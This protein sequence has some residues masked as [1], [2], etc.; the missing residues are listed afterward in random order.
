MTILTIIL[1]IIPGILFSFF[2]IRQDKYEQEPK[3]T[4]AISFALGM[5]VTGIAYGIEKW[6]DDK[7]QLYT[8]A[9]NIDTYEHFGILMLSAF[10]ITALTEELLKFLALIVFAYQR[11]DFNE[12]MDGIVYSVMIAM[13]FATVENILYTQYGWRTT[14]VRA[15]TAVPAHVVFGIIIGYYAGLAKFS[16]DQQIKY[17][18]MGLFIAVFVHGLYDFFII[19]EYEEWLMIMATAILVVGL[20]IARKFILSHQKNSPFKTPEPSVEMV[21]AIS[22]PET[23]SIQEETPV[24]QEE[25]NEIMSAVLDEMQEEKEED[26]KKEEE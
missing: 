22:P 17:L 2:I 5:L 26:K 21:T 8:A 6:A 20:L 12:P 18:L 11:D 4:L 24:F 3:V 13:G 9:Q 23:P 10:I 25:D 16:K 1:A 14:L 7:M 15:F 19:Q